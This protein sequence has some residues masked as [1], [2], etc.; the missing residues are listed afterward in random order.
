MVLALNAIVVLSEDRFLARGR[1]F[2][3]LSFLGVGSILVYVI[4]EVWTGLLLLLLLQW[5]KRN[6]SKR[7]KKK[8][9]KRCGTSGRGVLCVG[10]T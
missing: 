1:F 4:F 7:K 6:N 5:R 8:K 10:E 9:Q 2:P 3:L